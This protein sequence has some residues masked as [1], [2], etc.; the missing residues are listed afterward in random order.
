MALDRIMT[1]A[2]EEGFGFDFAPLITNGAC[3]GSSAG[4]GV[5][6]VEVEDDFVADEV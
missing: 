4:G 1:D 3:L 5:F 2:E 6:R